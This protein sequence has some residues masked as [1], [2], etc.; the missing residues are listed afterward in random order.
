[1]KL[2]KEARKG[3][4]A[5]FLASFSN[6]RLDEEKVR[7]V[8]KQLAERKPRNYLEILQG[9]QRYVRLEVE[10]RQ[11]LIESA[12]DLDRGTRD[13]LRRSLKSKYGDDLT[14]QFKTSPELIGGLRIQVGS[15]VW[16]SSVQARLHTLQNE[17]LHA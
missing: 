1:M 16:D 5:L 9:Y 6:R 14:V 13:K 4:K 3:A 8:V 17:L 10:K 7:S 11:A 12:A 2:N 15:D